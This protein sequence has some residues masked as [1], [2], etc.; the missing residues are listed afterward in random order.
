LM[1]A[2]APDL[3]KNQALITGQEECNAVRQAPERG[4]YCKLKSATTLP[5]PEISSD[6][7]FCRYIFGVSMVA[8]QDREDRQSR[9]YWSSARQLRMADDSPGIRVVLSE[10]NRVS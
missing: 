1:S 6:S 7:S 4:Q 5:G 2:F 8:L 9:N 10:R 3:L